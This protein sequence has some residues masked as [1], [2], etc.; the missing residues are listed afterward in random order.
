LIVE[1]PSMP[2]YPLH[3]KKYMP[4][5][6]LGMCVA[7]VTAHD[8]GNGAPASET[9]VPDDAAVEDDDDAVDAEDDAEEEDEPPC[10]PPDDDAATVVVLSPV[11]IGLATGHPQTMQTKRRTV[12]ANLIASPCFARSLASGLPARR[13]P[14]RRSGP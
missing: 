6:L 11:A 10:P 12:R 14:R 7:D 13:L 4:I 9:T 8:T 1:T 2:L 5:R 3:P